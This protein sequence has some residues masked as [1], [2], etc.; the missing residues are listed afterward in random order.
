MAK[1]YLTIEDDGYTVK[2]KSE[3]N[4]MFILNRIVL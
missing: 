1:K 2:V 4:V 3:I